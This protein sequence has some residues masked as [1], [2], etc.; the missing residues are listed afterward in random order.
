MLLLL[1]YI[2]I[3]MITPTNRINGMWL[4]YGGLDF[5]NI[6]AL[7]TRIRSNRV[8]F[9]SSFTGATMPNL[10]VTYLKQEQL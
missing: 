8:V 4:Q 7:K 10:Y 9:N 3:I 6:S 1:E 2:L 5:E